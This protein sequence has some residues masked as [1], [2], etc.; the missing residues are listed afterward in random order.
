MKTI[1]DP[2]ASARR[3]AFTNATTAEESTP[4][5]RRRS[6]TRKR[7][8]GAACSIRWRTRS[9]R[10]FVDPKNTNPLTR[11]IWT[12]SESPRSSARSLAGRSTFE[13]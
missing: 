11:R 6:I 1:S 10:Q 2:A 8:G 13:R 5:T 3:I 7:G 9:S 12:W 4:V